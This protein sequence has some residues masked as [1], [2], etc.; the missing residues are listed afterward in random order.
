MRFPPELYQLETMLAQHLPTLRP[1]QQRGLAVWVYGT[2]L[3]QSACQ[4]AVITALLTI[5]TWHTHVGKLY[6]RML[7]WRNAPRGYR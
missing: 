5:G 6:V 3:A 1:A 2:M 7:Y 4:N